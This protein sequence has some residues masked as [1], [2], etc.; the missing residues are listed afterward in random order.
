MRQRLIVREAHH[1]PTQSFENVLTFG[2][3][4]GDVFSCVN[5][6]I[7]FDNQFQAVAG[8]VDAGLGDGV[9]AAEFVAVDPAGAEQGPDAALGEA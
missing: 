1:G 6:T 7:D 3:I 4:Q 2:V 8:E 5:A 9:L